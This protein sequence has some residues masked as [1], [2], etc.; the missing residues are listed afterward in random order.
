MKLLMLSLPLACLFLI[1]ANNVFACIDTNCSYERRDQKTGTIM[2]F[3][4]YGN[5]IDRTKG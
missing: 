2:H 1:S 3:D 4:K 5:L